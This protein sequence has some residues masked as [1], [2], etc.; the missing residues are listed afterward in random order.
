M[1]DRVPDDV[2]TLLRRW[3]RG[4]NDAFQQVVPLI[5]HELRR[6]ARNQLRRERADHTVLTGTLV[7]EAYVR[8]VDCQQLQW[9]DRNHFLAT[10]ATIMR[11]VLVDEARKRNSQKRGM[12]AGSVPLDEVPV[13]ARERDAQWIALDE[14]LGHLE[15]EFP[16]KCRV[17]ELRYFTGL[18]IEETAEVLGLSPDIVKREWRTAKMWLQKEMQ[19]ARAGNGSGTGQEN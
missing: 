2:T 17:V 4:E 9:Q 7:H 16:R 6:L 19:I 13:V 8:L 1:D 11:R 10:A 15:T 18:T 14:A 5:Y 3:N 12:G